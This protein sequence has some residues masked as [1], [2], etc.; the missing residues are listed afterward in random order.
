MAR[1]RL[2]APA[3]KSFCDLR[4]MSSRPLLA[5][6]LPTLVASAIPVHTLLVR[7]VLAQ[8]AE[9]SAV[10]TLVQPG[11]FHQPVLEGRGRTAGEGTDVMPSEHGIIVARPFSDLATYQDPP[12]RS[13][14]SRMNQDEPRNVLGLDHLP[15][16]NC[17]AVKP[18]NAAPK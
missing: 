8:G 4:F 14:V 6:G 10:N 2:D 16:L 3:L 17:A 9:P 18:S 15:E 11:D 5:A 7:Q 12:S 1:P 13:D